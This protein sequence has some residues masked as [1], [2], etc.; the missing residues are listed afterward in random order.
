MLGSYY[1]CSSSA[2]SPASRSRKSHDR[3][4]HCSSLVLLPPPLYAY[5]PPPKGQPKATKIVIDCQSIKLEKI[6]PKTSKTYSLIRFLIDSPDLTRFKSKITSA[7]H[8]PS[9]CTGT[10]IHVRCV[11]RQTPHSSS[12][13]RRPRD[14]SRPGIESAAI[15]LPDRFHTHHRF[16]PLTEI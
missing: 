11:A 7:S 2:P 4:I 9:L 15:S 13:P 8:V 14:C 3:Q 1:A 5:Y 16:F 6:T 12:S 10:R